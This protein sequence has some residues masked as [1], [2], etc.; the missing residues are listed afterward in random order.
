MSLENDDQEDPDMPVNLA[1]RNRQRQQLIAAGLDQL[2]LSHET[3]ESRQ[4]EIQRLSQIDAA[5][6]AARTEVF[7]QLCGNRKALM[8]Y[9]A[10]LT[11]TDT[12]TWAR[13]AQ[14]FTR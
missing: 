6:H 5:G 2:Q 14:A 13:L 8:D 11:G 1:R 3:P 4:D 7:T 12:L 9:L 10:Y